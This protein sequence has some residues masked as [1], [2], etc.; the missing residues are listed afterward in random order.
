MWKRIIAEPKALVRSAEGEKMTERKPLSHE[1]PFRT[2]IVKVLKEEIAKAIEQKFSRTFRD[3]NGNF[4]V[5]RQERMELGSQIID[6]LIEKLAEK[7]N[8]LGEPNL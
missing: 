2:M 5:G 1:E 3:A 8:L 6:F 7:M 4:H